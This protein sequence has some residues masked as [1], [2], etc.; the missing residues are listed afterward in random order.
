M[1]LQPGLKGTLVH[2]V[3]SA[4]LA[5]S[6]GNDMP[7]F[8]TPIM[9]WLAEIACMRAIEPAIEASQITLGY[10]HEVGHLAPTPENWTVTFTAELVAI[11][12]KMLVFEVAAHDGV[13]TVLSG[14]HTR[15]MVAR[16][17]FAEKVR[18]KAASP[19]SRC[20]RPEV[21]ASPPAVAAVVRERVE[22]T[23]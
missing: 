6:W 13:D 2:N 20:R 22:E 14:R 19:P 9:L 4:D 7:V 11:D 3:R 21:T 10:R 1:S 15:A 8:A 23:A 16:D 5:S 17:R 12:G 18:R